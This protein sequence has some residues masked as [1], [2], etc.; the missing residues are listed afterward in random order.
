M[1]ELAGRT[2]EAPKLEEQ[3]VDQLESDVMRVRRAH[4]LY[5]QIP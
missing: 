5:P 1:E 4:Q 3:V 2:G